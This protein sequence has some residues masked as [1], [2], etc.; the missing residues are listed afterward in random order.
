M[1]CNAAHELL[2]QHLDGAPIESPELLEHLRQCPDCQSLATA[3]R[4]LQE[5]LRLLML[6]PPPPDLAERIA[7]RVGLDRRRVR[8]RSRRRWA[9]SLALAAGLFV[10]LTLRLD[11]R[12]RRDDAE[13]DKQGPVAAQETPEATPTL[14]E[15]VAEAGEAVAALTSQTADETVGQT[16][17][18]VPKVTGPSLPQVD[19][20]SMEPPT[21]PLREAG[22]GVSR[23]LEPVT[24]SAR[25][26]VGLFLRELPPMDVGQKGV[27][28]G[29]NKKSLTQ[30]RKERKGKKKK[31]S[32]LFPFFVFLC[33]LCAFA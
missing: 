10:A 8:R 20:E 30:R 11:W 23:G 29:S 4:R 24:T 16:R 2:Q 1:K 22:E 33:A 25:R 32:G 6:P 17:W 7:D 18:L 5:G 12:G 13:T 21:R 19:L 31:Q 28:R 9:V 3:T 26:A 15:S 14:R 27:V